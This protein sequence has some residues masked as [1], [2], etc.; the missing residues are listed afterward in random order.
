MRF[1]PVVA[2]LTALS[3]CSPFIGTVNAPD[4]R[5]RARAVSY[6]G[7][8][9]AD[10]AGPCL[11]HGLERQAGYGMQA[12]LRP[13]PTGGQEVV[14]RIDGDAMV[15]LDVI[16]AG[17]DQVRVDYYLEPGLIFRGILEGGVK[18]AIQTCLVNASPRTP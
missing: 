17:P 8:A 18:R 7:A 9:A 6:E 10:K 4:L 14:G 5:E 16:Q 2:A 3:G 11:M 12:A 1:L 15:V 13:S